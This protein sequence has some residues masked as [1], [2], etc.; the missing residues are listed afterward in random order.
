MEAKGIVKNA[1]ERVRAA[2]S[3]DIAAE[4]RRQLAEVGAGA[5]SLRA[6]ARELGMASSAMYRYFPSRDDLLT[7]LIVE[8]YDALGEVAETAALTR[9]TAFLRWQT[10]CRAIRQWALDHPHEYVLLYGSPVPGYHAPPITLAPASRV[11]LVLANLIADA[12]R[13]GELAPDDGPALPR[14]VATQVRP[15]AELAMPAVPLATVAQA[16]LVWAQLFGQISFELFERFEGIVEKPE[17]LFE[18]AV[19][20]MA[21]QLGIRS[22]RPTRS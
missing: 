11:T 12:H 4:A 22:T 5:L 19:T 9:G 14:A 18:H 3:A 21:R 6:V 7:T 16:L 20:M 17:V 8:A 2:V 13:A 10:V 1:R 15:V